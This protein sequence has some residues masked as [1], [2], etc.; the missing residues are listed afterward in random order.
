M[1]K[2]DARKLDHKTLEELRLRAVRKVQ[3]G[4]SP[5]LVGKALGINR[6]TIYDWLAKYRAG[7]WDALRSKPTPGA[8][9]KVNGKKMQWIFDTVYIVSAPHI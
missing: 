2:D 4:E 3:S 8:K 7:G 9:P 1:R 5:E 6:T